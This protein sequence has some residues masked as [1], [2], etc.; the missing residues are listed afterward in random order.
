ME[1][2]AHFKTLLATEA[3]LNIDGQMVNIN[4]FCPVIIDSFNESECTASTTPV[5][6]IVSLVLGINVAL[7]LIVI[8]HFVVVAIIRKKTKKSQISG[9]IA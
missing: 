5:I 7:I 2:A 9:E 6:L 8:L 4:V 3:V 1:L